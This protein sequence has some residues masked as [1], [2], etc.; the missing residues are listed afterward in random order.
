MIS[1]HFYEFGVFSLIESIRALMFII[2][3]LAALKLIENSTLYETM[4]KYAAKEITEYKDNIHDS[5]ERYRM[6][7][8]MA[9]DGVWL[10]DKDFMTLFVNPKMEELLGYSK[11]EMIGRSWYDF[12][13]PEW[14]MRAKELEKRI[15]SGVK[16]PHEFLFIR[17]DGKK[18]LTRISTTPLYDKNGNFDGAIGIL[19]DITRQKE[20]EDALN[21][22][23]ML[24]SIAQS[25][26]I[27][28]CI[29]NPDYTIEWYNDQH[30]EWFGPLES[31]KGRNCFE[32]FEG[33][34]SQCADC[35][36][37][38]VFEGSDVAVSERVGMT[39]LDGSDRSVMITA[40]PIRDARGNV[41]QVVEIGQDITKQKE[42]I[43]LHE[44]FA[45]E[46]E[47]QVSEKTRKLSDARKA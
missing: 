24:N 47:V 11:E 5:D 37:K 46:L 8:E 2:V 33:E 42:S 28:M 12:G 20:A 18:V 7:V 39:M 34:D 10:L 14:I 38:L 44:H 3:G 26:G 19:S 35:P 31:T 40:A 29:I 36:V 16:K 43:I 15:E 6:L 21:V 32:V 9:Q 4:L 25:A 22:K 23:D 17:K 30:A 45:T 13:D 1:S 27:G 41:I